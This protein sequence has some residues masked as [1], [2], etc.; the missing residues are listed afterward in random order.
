MPPDSLPHPFRLDLGE[1]QV[2]VRG[3]DGWF[4]AN[5]RDIYLGRALTTYGEYNRHEADFLRPL[6]EPGGVVVEVGAN[7]GSHTVG[8]A[9]QVGPSGRVMAIEAQPAIFRH[10][11]ANVAL[12]G[13]L[14]V[15]CRQCGLG[16]ERGTLRIPPID[17]SAEGNFGGVSL[18]AGDEGEAVD[19]FRLDDIFPY[20]RLDLL[21][22][23]VEG[24]ETEV[25][26][27]AALTILRHG[28]VIYLENDR[29]DRSLDLIDTLFTMGYRLWWHIPPLFHPDNFFGERENVY[30][31]VASFNMVGVPRS[32][33]VAFDG[34]EEVLDPGFHPLRRG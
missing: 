6:C 18:T 24:M 5:T 8:L 30:G 2:L 14:N 27:G 21:K 9:K 32:S 15:D 1:G 13:L 22:I 17:Y 23:D 11:C 33:G 4:L 31:N 7:I 26:R 19:I 12:N 34:L 25:L 20:T 10:L 28:P 16:G 3:R 29:V